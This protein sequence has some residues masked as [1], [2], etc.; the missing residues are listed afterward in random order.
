MKRLALLLVLAASAPAFAQGAGSGSSAGSGA[1]SAA[2][3]AAG[4]GAGSGSNQIV[5]IL[6]P[7]VQAPDVNAAASPSVLR[8]GERFT[9][10]ITARHAADVEVNLREPVE[11]GGSF[12]VKRKL[13]EDRVNSD[14]TKTR[15]WQIEVYAWDVGELRVPP[16]G[17]TFT[18]NGKAGQVATNTVPINVTGVLGDVVDDP[19][20]MRGNAPPV[21]LMSRDWFWAWIAGGVGALLGGI[22]AF[23]ILRKRRKKQVRSLIGTLVAS[24]PTPRKLDMTSERALAQLMAI[25]KSGILD[26]AGERKEGYAQMVEVLREYIA[27]RYRIDTHDLTSYELM[28]A[29]RNAA[30]ENEQKLIEDW[31]ERCDIVKYGG[32]K[33]TADDAHGVLEAARHVVI[34]TTRAPAP[35]PS[36]S[37]RMPQA[38]ESGRFPPLT[39]SEKA[40]ADK[41]A[42]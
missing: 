31:L 40:A 4:S 12:E 2:G 19:K 14:G 24:T 28:R 5:I 15:E 23:M 39:D 20:L 18:A 7:D 41:E 35:T 30:P 29:L 32:F 27:A 26:R 10:F 21:S 17:V 11:L 16:I 3:S 1:G 33:A 22:I 38:S 9:L 34:S 42:T 25:E 37:G 6:P 36:A 8:L 13:S